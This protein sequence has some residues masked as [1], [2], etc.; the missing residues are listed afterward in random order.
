MHSSSSSALN[1]VFKQFIQEVIQKLVLGYNI[2]W[3]NQIIA[4]NAAVTFVAAPHSLLNT[5]TVCTA[6]PL[7]VRV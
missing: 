1:R 2:F 7:W 5:F 6:T 4:E 3:A